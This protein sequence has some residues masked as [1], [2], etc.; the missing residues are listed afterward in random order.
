MTK[1]V[2]LAKEAIELFFSEAENKME[3]DTPW[4]QHV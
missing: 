4:I 1:N 2:L 3:Q